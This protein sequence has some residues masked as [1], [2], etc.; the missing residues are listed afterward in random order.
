MTVS[1]IYERLVIVVFDSAK[2][3]PLRII[4][5]NSNPILQLYDAQKSMQPDPFVQQYS[6]K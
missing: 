5:V 1:F 6:S 4:N 2:E 3:N